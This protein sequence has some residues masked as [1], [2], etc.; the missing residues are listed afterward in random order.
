MPNYTIIGGPNGAGKSTFS[1]ELSASQALIFDPDKSKQQIEL[2]YPDI[3]HEALE[4]AVHNTYLETEFIALQQNRDLTVESNLRNT[5]LGNR[6]AFIKTQQGWETN[7][8]FMML[9][10]INASM[11]RVNLRVRKNGHYVDPES[12]ISNFNSGLKNLLEVAPKF[13]NVMLICAAAT[14]GFKSKPLILLTIKENELVQLK[15]QMPRWTKPLVGQISD[16]LI[17]PAISNEMEWPAEN[18]QQNRSKSIGR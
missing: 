10:D 8:I 15:R 11:D 17:T 16:L 14:Y 2:L 13:D 12:I 6:A 9:P 5:Y 3:S 7:L 1:T 18:Q 4:T